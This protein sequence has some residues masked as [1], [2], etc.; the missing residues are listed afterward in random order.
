MQQYQLYFSK[1]QNELND[2]SVVIII[3]V[4]YRMS[5]ITL[6]SMN[7]YDAEWRLLSPAQPTDDPSL[8]NQGQNFL[9][10]LPQ[11]I[12]KKISQE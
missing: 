1:I 8:P 12:R 2:K 9:Q 5:F 11:F 10:R 4:H 3:T 6:L 7:R